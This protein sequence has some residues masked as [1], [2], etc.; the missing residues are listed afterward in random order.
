VLKGLETLCVVL[1]CVWSSFCYSCLYSAVNICTIL[2]EIVCIFIYFYFLK[3]P[4]LGKTRTTFLVVVT[5]HLRHNF[6]FEHLLSE[7]RHSWFVSIK[8]TCRISSYVTCLFEYS[9]PYFSVHFS[10]DIAYIPLKHWDLY[11]TCSIWHC[12]GMLERN[13]GT[14]SGTLLAKRT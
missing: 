5:I 8:I 13:S 10:F 4:A 14:E 3:F 7:F 9:V 1:I 6:E 2:Y 11:K 12:E